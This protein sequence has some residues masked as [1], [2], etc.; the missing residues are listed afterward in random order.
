MFKSHY[1]WWVECVLERMLTSTKYRCRGEL[2]VLTLD[3]GH[4]NGVQLN[5]RASH[6][7]MN[8]SRLY[9]D[10]NLLATLPLDLLADVL[11]F[12]RSTKDILAVARC[13]KHFCQLLSSSSRASFMWKRARRFCFPRPMPNPPGF[14][15]ESSY[16]AFVFDAGDCEVS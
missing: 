12:T 4:N 13:S 7:T 9:T 3:A 5:C 6:D 14:M 16:A 11:V 10:T 1:E 15:T 8:S 2:Q